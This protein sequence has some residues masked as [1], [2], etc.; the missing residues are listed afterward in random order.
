MSRPGEG[1]GRATVSQQ[2]TE[3]RRDDA[4][5]RADL[6]AQRSRTQDLRYDLR[7]DLDAVFAATADANVDDEHDPEGATI[8]FERSQLSRGIE[9]ADARLGDID[10]ALARLDTGSYGECEHCGADIGAARLAAR[11][12]SGKCIRCARSAR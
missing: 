2:T 7:A 9:A 12:A 4:R 3:T 11:P 5:V 10:A 8:A 6:L 1:G